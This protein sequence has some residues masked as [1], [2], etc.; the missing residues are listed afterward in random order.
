[1]VAT[2]AALVAVTA[3]ATRTLA[4]AELFGYADVMRA[5][6]QNVNQYEQARL[7]REQAYQSQI[8]T[9]KKKFDYLMYVRAN[10]PTFTQE[11][12]R[13]ANQVLRRI[14]TNSNPAEISSG[15]ALNILLDDL[16]RH[17]GKRVSMEP[18]QLSDEV[19]K[20]LNVVKNAGNL[21]RLV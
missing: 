15:T 6:G 18:I 16:R 10:T 19:L 5:Y 21:G 14:Q 20:Q 2:V 1:M 3:T 13:V 11:Q 9:A 17:I 12:A 4:G 7:L 8:D